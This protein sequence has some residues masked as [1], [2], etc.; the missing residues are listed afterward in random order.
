MVGG[1]N[2][3]AELVMGF[4][5]RH[6]GEHITGVRSRKKAAVRRLLMRRPQRGSDLA[7]Q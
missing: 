6:L 7:R 3:G 2:A 1:L 5:V 4:C